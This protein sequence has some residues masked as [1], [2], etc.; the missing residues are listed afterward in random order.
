MGIR[1]DKELLIDSF[2][3]FRNECERSQDILQS[4][5]YS[6]KNTVI[7]ACSDIKELSEGGVDVINLD[8]DISWEDDERIY[9]GGNIG[10][11]LKLSGG[12]PGNGVVRG[13]V[14]TEANL[15]RCSTLYF[16][17]Q[18]A[19]SFYEGD[20]DSL[21]LV[22]DVMIFKGGNPDYSNA[23]KVSVIGYFDDTSD[24]LAYAKEVANKKGID[25]LLVIDY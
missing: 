18:K 9:C 5:E 20:K 21:I 19:K 25:K 2:E 11:V 16:C 12:H 3:E 8:A 7:Y 4:V 1:Q 10:I 13:V 15:C 17:L 14:N 23:F 22:P 24:K 6:I